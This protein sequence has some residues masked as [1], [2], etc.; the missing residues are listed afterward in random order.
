[1]KSDME[2]P[3]A[4]ASAKPPPAGAG[5]PDDSF[6]PIRAIIRTFHISS[7]HKLTSIV[8]YTM[9]TN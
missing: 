7:C 2:P 9:P 4:T 6:N 1:M 3:V 8:R 5:T